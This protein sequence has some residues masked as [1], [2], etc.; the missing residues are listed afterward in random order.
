VG[1]EALYIAKGSSKVKVKGGSSRHLVLCGSPV[2]PAQV[3]APVKAF[4]T[5][6]GS[7]RPDHTWQGRTDVLTFC[8]KKV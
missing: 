1:G 8:L 4:G 2:R 7:R 5:G 3:S 6:Q